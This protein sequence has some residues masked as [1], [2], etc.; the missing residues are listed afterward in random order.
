[1]RRKTQ[2]L[3]ENRRMDYGSRYHKSISSSA[4]AAIWPGASNLVQVA[5]SQGYFVMYVNTFGKGSLLWIHTGSGRIFQPTF[6]NIK[7]KK[8]K[9][10]AH[11]QLS[12]GY[13]P[14]LQKNQ[15]YFNFLICFDALLFWSDSQSW[16][17]TTNQPTSISPDSSVLLCYIV[18]YCFSYWNFTQF[19]CFNILLSTVWRTRRKYKGNRLHISSVQQYKANK[20]KIHLSQ[21]WNNNRCNLKQ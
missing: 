13:M 9:R 11:R 17:L 8:K 15:T 16:I 10:W 7:K 18:T 19:L 20:L 12:Q 6:I 5:H 1:M 4:P 2:N 21:M 3:V 14:V